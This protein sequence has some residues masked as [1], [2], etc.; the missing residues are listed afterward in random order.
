MKYVKKWMVVPYEET[1][2]PTD[3]EKIQKILN[4]KSLNNDIKVKLINQIKTS[5]VKKKD[6][7]HEPLIQ[8]TSNQDQPQVQIQEEVERNPLVENIEIPDNKFNKT[9]ADETFFDAQEDNTFEHSYDYLHPAAS[10]R[11]QD[12]ND[13]S[14]LNLE[15]QEK[16]AQK[17]KKTEE[18]RKILTA[19]RKKI[20]GP[21]LPVNTV[22]INNLPQVPES[23]KNKLEKITK[24]TKKIPS[25]AP[26]PKI[27]IKTQQ[28]S[29]N[30]P[31]TPIVQ[32]ENSKLNWTQYRKTPS[33]TR[34][35]PQKWK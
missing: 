28:F 29:N 13:K 20:Q 34:T 8:T 6:Q 17:R 25:K 3:Q 22:A 32:I 19:K 30:S 15:K 21:S 35:L 4:N 18:N 24:S 2:L 9:T 31:S 16:F 14:F 27:T 26:I 10:T 7:V 23:P 5:L 12:I 1:K 11:S 33:N